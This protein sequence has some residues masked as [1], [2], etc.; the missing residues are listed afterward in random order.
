MQSIDWLQ[1]LQLTYLHHKDATFLIVAGSVIVGFIC[2][3][4]LIIL[5]WLSSLKIGYCN[6]WYLNHRKCCNGM[7]ECSDFMSYSENLILQFLLYII[8][9]CILAVIAIVFVWNNELLVGSGLPQLKVILSGYSIPHFFDLQTALLKSQSALFIISSGLY[10][11]Y[12]EIMVHTSCSIFYYLCSILKIRNEATKRSLLSVASAIG[13]SVGF[14]TNMGGILFSLEEASFYFPINVLWK[15]FIGCFIATT[16]SKFLNPNPNTF[17]VNWDR[18]WHSFEIPFFI[19][20]GSI[21]G[22]MGGLFIK[23]N[24]KYLKYKSVFSH[25]GCF[26]LTIIFA[27]FNKY[28][29]LNPLFLINHLFKD[30]KESDYLSLCSNHR[31]FELIF[32]FAIISISTCTSYG[33]NFSGGYYVPVMTMGALYGRLFGNFV[34]SLQSVIPVYFAS[35]SLNTDVCITPGLYALIGSAALF[36]GVTKCTV[37]TIIIMME[38]SG[39][40]NYIIPMLIA[41]ASSKYASDYIIKQGLT[42]A[43][44]QHLRF[45]YLDNKLDLVSSVTVKHVMRVD[46]PIIHNGI[47]LQ[48]LYG[49]LNKDYLYFPVLQPNLNKFMGVVDSQEIMKGLA[50]FSVNKIVYFDHGDG[51]ILRPWIDSSPITVEMDLKMTEIVKIFQRLGLRYVVVMEKGQFKGIVNRT[52]V[53]QW[54]NKRN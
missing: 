48:D 6:I 30:C 29:I 4:N 45:P 8:L 3:I 32:A 33:H 25:L 26:L 46:V 13:I 36:T 5:E 47:L 53:I 34:F 22:A 12:Q 21:G 11:S 43:F 52:D 2:S 31:T 44:I 27:W 50:H 20:L 40:L 14:N 41:V 35:C 15:S 17:T 42:V 54:I 19:I 23:L 51:I 49:V 38:L 7:I 1:Q 18:D 9:G 37:S 24:I 39:K 16:I 10:L 28:T